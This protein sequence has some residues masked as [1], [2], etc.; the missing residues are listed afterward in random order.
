MTTKGRL[1]I[2]IREREREKKIEQWNK[3]KNIIIIS[4][5]PNII[6]GH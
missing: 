1:I 6:V 2:L 5:W 4:L 3:S